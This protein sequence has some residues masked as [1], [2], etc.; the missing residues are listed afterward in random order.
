[1][2]K[3]LKLTV[4]YKW[5]FI[6]RMDRRFGDTACRGV[7]IW[8]GWENDLPQLPE[9]GDLVYINLLLTFEPL[10]QCTLHKLARVLQYSR[11]GLDIY[12]TIVT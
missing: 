3:F 10:I 11:W 4:N 8:R 7:C 12:V 5:T 1:M 9:V 6:H 2:S